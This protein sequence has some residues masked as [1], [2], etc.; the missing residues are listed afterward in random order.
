MHLHGQG[1]ASAASQHG[2]SM[3]VLLIGMSIMAMMLTVAMPV[4]KQMAQRENEEELVFRGQQYAR[5]IG[6]FGRKFANAP[7]PTIDALVEQRFLRR[8]YKDPITQDDFQLL[9]AGQP[10]GAAGRGG[11][12][13]QAGQPSQ[14]GGLGTPQ[15]T[16]IGGRST[17]TTGT[18][19]ATVAGI[20]GVT[21][22]SKDKSI[23]IFNGRTHYNEWAFVYTPPVQAPGAGAPGTVAPGQTPGRGQGPG[24]PGT[25]PDGRGRGGQRGPGGPSGTSSPFGRGLG[26]GIGNFGG[27]SQQPNA[28]PPPGR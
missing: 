7:P 10:A 19:G 9:L 22:K 2:Y 27:G 24:G 3:A 6:L 15:S 20:I 26:S 12:A 25:S 4:W 23:R 18:A 16:N 13:G 8:R 5:A 14:G 28:P 11:P 21:S 1:R 17:T